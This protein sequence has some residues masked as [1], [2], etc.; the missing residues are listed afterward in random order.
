MAHG[1]YL[2]RV[3]TLALLLGV[4]ALASTTEAKPS[5]P[6]IDDSDREAMRA[7]MEPFKGVLGTCKEQAQTLCGGS[8]RNGDDEHDEDRRRLKRGP[9]AREGQRGGDGEGGKPEG[10]SG[11]G[12]GLAVLCLSDNAGSL[13]GD[14]AAAWG[15]VS[16]A[17]IEAAVA[18]VTAQLSPRAQFKRACAVD[19]ES[20]CDTEAERADVVACLEASEGVS[21]ACIAVITTAK[22]KLEERRQRFQDTCSADIE[23]HCDASAD[24]DVV[25]ECLAAADG[26]S[27]DC[28]Q[29]VA[30]I[31]ERHADDN[32]ED[33]LF[34]VVDGGSLAASAITYDEFEAIDAMETPSTERDN[35]DGRRGDRGLPVGVIAA[36]AGGCVAL[37]A[38]VAVIV[39][40]R[41]RARDRAA[42]PLPQFVPVDTQ[43]DSPTMGPHVVASH[44]VTPRKL[45]GQSG[46]GVPPSSA[47]NVKS[48]SG[49]GAAAAA[50]VVKVAVSSTHASSA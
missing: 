13:T 20:F 31:G 30:R 34:G 15:A 41:R 6:P 43:P 18:A 17:D 12:A 50:R 38:L 32:G 4:L 44:V 48:D 36:A 46:A 9:G 26:V 45:S 2:T 39:V 27:D 3:A 7:I 25:L 22:E 11:P 21:D 8:E 42:T 40:M 49:C 5:R 29:L 1:S 28:A 16:G 35:R 10:A 23:A 14:C 47:G 24:H 37:V 33:P 19:V